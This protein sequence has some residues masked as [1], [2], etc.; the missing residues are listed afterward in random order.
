MQQPPDPDSAREDRVDSAIAEYLQA[1]EAGR[2]PD[3]EAFLRSHPDLAEELTEFLDDREHFEKLASRI[4]D[5]SEP[6]RGLSAT[7]PIKPSAH[8]AGELPQRVGDYELLE[9]IARGGMGVVYRA[10]QVSL[11]RPVA[12]KMILA[13]QLA[14]TTD[15]ARFRG[16]AE[17]AARLDH[18]NIVPIHEVGEHEGQPFFSMRFVDG[19]DL[20]GHLAE[21]QKSPRAAANL[22][23][24]LAD[25]IHH[26]HQRGIL[27]RDLKPRN[28]LLNA[29]GEPQIT[30]FGLAKLLEA[31]GS[32]T[33]AGAALGTASYMPPEQARG[34]GT[35]TTSSD[36]YSLGA[37][38]YELLTGR[39]PFRAATPAETILDV[40]EKEPTPPSATDSS[41]GRDLNT[42]CLKCLEKEPSRRY[43]SAEALALDLRRWL[44]GRPIEARPVGSTER[45]WRG[46]RRNPALTSVIAAALAIIVSM[47]GFYIRSLNARNAE[48]EEALEQTRL[49]ENQTRL[50]GEETQDALARSQYEQARALA[51]A[52]PPG[53]RWTILD[54]VAEVESLRTR[55]RFRQ[56]SAMVEGRDKQVL[57][58]QW[59]LRSEAVAALLLADARIR[60]QTRPSST[61]QP[62]LT[63]DNRLAVTIGRRNR[64]SEILITDLG[65]GNVSSRWSSPTLNESTAIGMTPSARRG[66]AFNAFTSTLV[67]WDPSTGEARQELSW[68]K[69]DASTDRASG[70]PRFVWSSEIVFSPDGGQLAIVGR[71][72]S[73]QTLN[74]WHLDSPGRA[75][76]LTTIAENTDIGPPVFLANGS[77]LAYATGPQTITVWNATEPRESSEIQLPLPLAGHFTAAPNGSRLAIAGASDDPN[78]GVLT[79]WD[80]SEGHETAQIVTDFALKAA[81]LAFHPTRDYLAAGTTD[82]RIFVI[83]LTRRQAILALPG[84]HRGRIVHLR[85][86]P[87]GRDLISWGLGKMG[88]EAMLTCRRFGLPPTGEIATQ[89][90]GSLFA[91]SPDGNWLV[92]THGR[93]G[94]IRLLDRKQGV[95]ARVF[96][97]TGLRSVTLMAFS[98]GSRRVVASDGSS[99]VVWKL[100]DG[101]EIARLDN[102]VGLR[103]VLSTVAFTSQG[104]CLAAE[105]VG[106]S[107]MSVWNVLE[108]KVVW[109]RQLDHDVRSA[110]FC[111]Q[112]NCLAAI[113]HGNTEGEIRLALIDSLTGQQSATRELTGKP[114]GPASLSPRG[115][116]LAISPQA[117]ESFEDMTKRQFGLLLPPSVDVVLE[118]CMGSSPRQTI[119]GPSALSERACAFSA[120]GRLLALGYRDGSIT[121]W[122]LHTHQQIFRVRY[123]NSPIE[124]LAFGAGS[125]LLFV[126][127]GSRTIGTID[128][129]RLRQDLA[130]LNLA[131]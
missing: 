101:G 62:G 24:V 111:A 70:P 96:E 78:Q 112:A 79:I 9:E 103:G 68:P 17:A 92:T 1:A 125:Q 43:G 90:P 69:A 93:E 74:L 53:R 51:I 75:Y 104:A 16:E 118:P 32:L 31:D 2:T 66:V 63:T 42:I 129:A 41:I 40:L 128:L 98:P 89:T 119:T 83:D 58:G 5:P 6:P 21:Y 56:E 23:A 100:P 34:D 87:D 99:A 82:G 12:V 72:G 117:T 123:R 38:L 57:P 22:I 20:T 86:S 47:T 124:Q 13:G 59:E 60:W 110:M 15:V 67:L 55:E 120:D 109:S 10:E 127:D 130:S 94:T 30:D 95:V 19:G 65:T 76:R 7:Q 29:E 115:N 73:K 36:V 84:A 46:C 88:A 35:A 108:K 27:H 113:S 3:R 81:P 122:D 45:I 77:K 126:G 18:P 52:G 71:H 33:Q 114:I 116:W 8:Q 28:I 26:A 121:L 85:W 48:T 61:A 106:G 39:P 11:R 14:S 37:I 49:A 54:L 44:E 50:A 91:A 105:R 25:A 80:L 97:D 4:T 131:W 102:T 64:D 107:R